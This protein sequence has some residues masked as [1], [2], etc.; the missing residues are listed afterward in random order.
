MPG[1]KVSQTCDRCSCKL[2]W[3]WLGGGRRGQ[4]WLAW[5]TAAA[6]LPPA[7]VFRNPAQLVQLCHPRCAKKCRKSLGKNTFARIIESTF[8]TPVQLEVLETKV[9]GV[10]KGLNEEWLLLGPLYF[11]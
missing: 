5:L 6:S 11:C 2:G 4:R 1:G 10:V 9:S 8:L 3:T 7:H